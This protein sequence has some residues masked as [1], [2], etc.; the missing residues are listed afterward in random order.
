[1]T[2]L[3]HIPSEVLAV[4]MQQGS[5][6]ACTEL[7]R[8]FKGLFHA[9][10]S[11]GD[12]AG[13]HD[14]IMSHLEEAFLHIVNKFDPK[15][16]ASFLA[17]LKTSLTNQALNLLKSEQTRKFYE[18]QWSQYESDSVDPIDIDMLTIRNDTEK[19]YYAINQLNDQE[20][21]VILEVALKGRLKK[22]VAAEM[23]ICTKTVTRR[24]EKALVNLRHLLEPLHLNADPSTDCEMPIA[25]SA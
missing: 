5:N 18:D 16:D 25:R 6:P 15:K 21:Q 20:K 24:L 4:N 1:M 12:A 10:A 17:Y 7:R 2:D 11:V 9:A 22:D 3:S 8:R 19:L 23:G 14:E 13:I